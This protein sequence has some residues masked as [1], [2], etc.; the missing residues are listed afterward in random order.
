[1]AKSTEKTETSSERIETERKRAEQ[2]SQS[3]GKEAENEAA[4][5]QAARPPLEPTIDALGM[6]KSYAN[7][8]QVHPG[9]E[10]LAIDF[11][12]S[13]SNILAPQAKAEIKVDHRIIVNYFMAKRLVG[14]LQGSIQRYEALFGVLETNIQKRVQQPPARLK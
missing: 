11:G 13:P 2:I 5:D 12:F 3:E 6:T 9:P 7:F 1:M 10:E 14:L 4:A 8:C